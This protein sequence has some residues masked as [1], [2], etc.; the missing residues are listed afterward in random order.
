MNKFG[1][2]TC[3][4]YIFAMKCHCFTIAGIFFLASMIGAK[5]SGRLLPAT[6]KSLSAPS[7]L[8]SVSGLKPRDSVAQAI[9]LQGK[10]SKPMQFKSPGSLTP[11]SVTDEPCTHPRISGITDTSKTQGAPGATDSA[12][13]MKAG[14][15]P[16]VR[17]ITEDK[18]IVQK[19]SKSTSKLGP[20]ETALQKFPK[21][22]D[23]GVGVLFDVRFCILLLSIVVIGAF[24]RYTLK[25]TNQPTFITT[26]RLSIMDKE[27]QTACRYIEKNYKNPELSLENI[28]GALVTGKAFLDALFHQELGLGVKEFITQVRINRA[29]ILIEK[30]TSVSA[31]IVAGETGFNDVNSFTDAFAFIV[32]MPFDHYRSARAK[33]AV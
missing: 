11:D 29:R 18:N 9:A 6:N 2:S 31:D 24:L 14:N 32:G 10:D 7:P 12:R 13:T 1:I 17:T 19:P 8:F 22:R 23:Y 16:N 21:H 30:D 27:V 25:K 26:T 4:M 5:D 28:C 3:L 15:P 33:N 20:K